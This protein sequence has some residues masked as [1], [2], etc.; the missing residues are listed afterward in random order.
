MRE[1][2]SIDVAAGGPGAAAV[3]VQAPV[4]GYPG[5]Q[6]AVAWP[7]IEADDRSVA[8]Q[9][10]DIGNAADIGDDAVFGGGA[11]HLVV[12]GGHQRSALAAGGDVAAAK[13]RDHGD[14]GQFG[15]GVRIPD[16]PGER[17]LH[18]GAVAQR[19]AVAADGGHLGRGHS[20]R[21]QQAV[22]GPCEGASQFHVH[23]S[24][25]VEGGQIGGVDQ[26][27]QTALERRLVG[28]RRGRH[29]LQ[30]VGVEI[31]QGRV[32]GVQAGA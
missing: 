5:I 7:G 6:Q 22:G 9:H 1:Q 25:V 14:A 16:L 28:R 4:T 23:L 11:K 3:E 8:H 32:D 20:R 17:H 31:H 2:R 26:R 18:V 10:G 24:D 21:L 30:R 12:E 27:C 13:I 29:H 15:E 19:L